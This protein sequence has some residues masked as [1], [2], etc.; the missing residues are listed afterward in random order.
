MQPFFFTPVFISNDE[1]AK[2]CSPIPKVVNAN[3][4]VTEGRVNT[5]ECITDYC[6]TQVADTKRFSNIRCG[7]IYNNN[8]AAASATATEISFLV[9][10]FGDNPFCQGLFID[11]K[12]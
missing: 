9:K 7:I 3:T 5:V 1:L 12:I 6:R 8:L 2:L 10:D 4:A 11:V